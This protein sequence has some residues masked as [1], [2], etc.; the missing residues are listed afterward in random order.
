MS[1]KSDTPL[2]DGLLITSVETLNETARTLASVLTQV[3]H[4]QMLLVTLQGVTN[5]HTTAI[6][7]S[8]TKAELLGEV[9][10]LAG[11]RRRDQH[12][13]RVLITACTI[14]LLVLVGGVGGA[15]QQFKQSRAEANTTYSQIAEDVCVQRSQTWDALQAFLTTQR[16]AVAA[17]ASISAPDK[18]ALVATY[19]RLMGSIAEVDCDKLGTGLASTVPPLPAG[20]GSGANLAKR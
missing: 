4:N 17:D 18:A 10:R 3:E 6:S 16:A 13:T 8:S 5:N 9:N 15:L 7:R 12:R 11:E 1:E 20:L 19:T 14:G 2:S